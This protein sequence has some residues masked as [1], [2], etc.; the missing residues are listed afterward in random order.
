MWSFDSHPSKSSCICTTC[1]LTCWRIYGLTNDRLCSQPT[2]MN[3]CQCGCVCT[4]SRSINWRTC[5]LNF[6]WAQSVA[7]TRI[8][9]NI[10]YMYIR[11]YFHK[12]LPIDGYGPCPYVCQNHVHAKA[13]N[14]WRPTADFLPGPF[15]SKATSAQ[16]LNCKK[17]CQICQCLSD[18]V[19]CMLRNRGGCWLNLEVKCGID[20]LA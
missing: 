6:M 3:V 12:R 14:E 4:A 7:Y 2:L 10:I 17:A 8:V 20:R 13:V 5:E 19:C 18:S 16:A 11:A 15:D 9:Y 1:R